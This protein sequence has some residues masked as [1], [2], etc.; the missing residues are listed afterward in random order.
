MEKCSQ[1]LL[2][3]LTVQRDL[4][5]EQSQCPQQRETDEGQAARKTACCQPADNIAWELNNSHQ[6]VV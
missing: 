1:V 2:L 6:E 5:K 3:L 4:D